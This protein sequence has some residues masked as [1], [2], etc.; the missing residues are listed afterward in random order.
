MTEFIDF[1]SVDPCFDGFSS[2]PM[3]EDRLARYTF[4]DPAKAAG[5]FRHFLDPEIIACL[6]LDALVRIEDQQVE[7]S[8]KERRDDLNFVCPVIVA[9]RELTSRRGNQGGKK[10]QML[11]SSNRVQIRIL[12]EHKSEFDDKLWYQ[13]LDSILIK[14]RRDG[15]APVLT[16]VLHTGPEA[17]RLDSPQ[18]RFKKLNLPDILL[19]KQLLLPVISIDLSSQTLKEIATSIHL[20]VDSK[21]IISI[22]K[23][24]Q[25]RAVSISSIREIT[26]QFYPDSTTDTQKRHFEAA[27]TYIRYK[28]PLV[29][30]AELEKMRSTM[31]LAHPIHPDSI[32][33]LELRESMEKGIEK[34]IEKGR[35]EGAYLNK[36]DIAKGMLVD[37]FSLESIT[38]YTGLPFSELEALQKTL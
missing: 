25:S 15:F 1:T 21:F 32:F 36:L 12:V 16:L 3:A 22:M 7:G 29:D 31:A 18:A 33:A 2:L 8:L 37:G 4:H 6:D 28:S 14:W 38:K 13:L 30:H 26:R 24:V 19:E 11:R 23:L 27:I 10:S 5:L 20:D 17:F 9:N 35:E 34:G